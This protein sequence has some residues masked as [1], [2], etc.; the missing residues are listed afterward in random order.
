M[1]HFQLGL[2]YIFLLRTWTTSLQ[3][4]LLEIFFSFLVFLCVNPSLS[5]SLGY[6]VVGTFFNWCVSLLIIVVDLFV[7]IHRSATEVY[8]SFHK[9]IST[10]ALLQGRA[11]SFNSFQPYQSSPTYKLKLQ[12]KK[13]ILQLW[14]WSLTENIGGRSAFLRFSLNLLCFFMFN[15]SFIIPG[16]N[17]LQA[18]TPH[19]LIYI[20]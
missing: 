7:Q 3:L 6:L 12:H 5:L 11:S 10:F 1:I 15:H 18:T 9:K 2:E 17:V 14:Q 8:A 13:K 4:T 19:Q 20:C 16:Q